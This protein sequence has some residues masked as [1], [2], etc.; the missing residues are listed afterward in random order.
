MEFIDGIIEKAKQNIKKIVLPEAK[1]LR[2]LKAASKLHN[3]KIAN[4]VLIGDVEEVNKLANENEINISE[5]EIINPKTSEKNKEYANVLYKLRK[6]KGMTKEEAKELINDEVY[7][8][9]LMV[10]EGDADGLV[11]GAI[12]S[13]ADTLRPALQILKT[14]P[15]VKLV[16]SFFIMDIPG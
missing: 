8:G 2:V 7:F 13:T 1:D 14:A 4:I 16:S 11:S 5:I 12:H 10:Y 9:M 6:A 15:G 3:E